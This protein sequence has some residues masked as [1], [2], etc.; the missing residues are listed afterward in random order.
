MSAMTLREARLTDIDALVAI[1]Y[2]SFSTDQMTRRALKSAIR[3]PTQLVYVA[4]AKGVVAGFMVLHIR[5]NSRLIRLYSIAVLSGFR[6]QGIATRLIEQAF[7]LGRMH[8]RRHITLEAR[9]EQMKLIAF[10]TALG[11]AP[12]SVRKAYYADG[13]DALFMVRRLEKPT[14]RQTP[15]QKRR[16]DIVVVPRE[17]DR[18]AVAAL[19]DHISHLEI[20]TAQQ[21]LSRQGDLGRAIRVINLCPA[22]E[23]LSSGY[24]VSLVAEARG[25]RTWATIDALSGLVD[26]KLYRHSLNELNKL[27][28]AA[29]QINMHP[30]AATR[31]IQL[32]FY[33]GQTDIDWARRLARRCYALFG[34]PILEIQLVLKNRQWQVDYLWPLAIASV[35]R[36]DLDRFVASAKQALTRRARSAQQ[37]KNAT[38]DLAILVD[39]GERLPPS[40]KRALHAFDKA[41]E[42]HGLRSEWIT[43]S[44][45]GRLGSFDALFIRATTQIGHYT[46]E[47]AI[48]AEQR[49][50]PVIDDPQSILRCSNKVFLTEALSRASVST[51]YTWMLTKSTL[52]TVSKQITYPAILKIP[53]GSFSRGMHKAETRDEL[54][55]FALPMLAKSFV[56]LAQ[57]FVPSD[58]DW[59]IGMLDGAPLF[60]CQYFM[61]RGH[62]QIYQ[63]VSPARVVSGGFRTVPLSD[64]PQAVLDAAVRSTLI[65]GRGLY[66]VDLKAV[67]DKVYVIEVNDNPNIDSG[68]EDQILGTRLYDAII[69]LLRDRILISKGLTEAERGRSK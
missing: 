7:R 6:G 1:E 34:V 26:R 58:F 57:E 52:E 62:W 31:K 29:A 12:R 60:A 59:R 61:S 9:A 56:I 44:D 30:G 24:Y 20:L 5:R 67:G 18:S 68:V 27:L 35:D 3:S 33:F 47:F 63:H 22:E 43:Q 32:E 69:Q 49:A 14:A 15:L 54:I 25:N 39:P 41:A 65:I 48:A 28:P 19:S 16:R 51:P 66:G 42:R 55:A 13:A 21:F 4:S 45:I 2:N 36:G 37:M 40:D 64:V 53:D 50:M 17:Q 23:Y 8:G 11:F 10:Y 46:H 38:F